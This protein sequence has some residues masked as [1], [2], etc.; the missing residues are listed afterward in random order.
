MT[1]NVVS[2]AEFFSKDHGV[3]TAY[4]N[5]VEMLRKKQIHVIINSRRQADILH[6]HTLGPF[7]LVKLLTSRVPT[8]VSAHIIPDS[9]KGSLKGE[10]YWGG[11]SSRYLRFFYNKADLV[12][13]VAPQVKKQLLDLGVKS[14]IEIFPNPINEDI[15]KKD[16]KCRSTGRKLLEI[17]ENDILLL[18][19]GQV[20]PRKGIED[21]I[22]IAKAL[23]QYKFRWIGGK[24]FKGLT[25]ENSKLNELIENKPDNF[26][27]AGPFSYSDMPSIYNGADIFLFPSLQE[28][29]PMAI[30]EAAACG[31][32]LLLKNLPEYKLL[33]VKGYLSADSVDDYE[34]LIKKLIE[35]GRFYKDSVTGSKYIAEKFSTDALGDTLI[36]YYQSLLTS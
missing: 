1:V 23:P 32:P 6:F 7:S 14:R 27:F 3:Y 12:L 9:F 19:A 13:A 11:I 21:F 4:I 8:V 15:F 22:L 36:N 17:T 35:D 18:G 34:K 24:P 33:Y 16:P 26:D 28:N 31:L 10:K 2:E 25:A 29:A 30:I 5:Q 20:Q